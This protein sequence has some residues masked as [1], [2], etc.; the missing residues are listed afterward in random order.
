VIDSNDSTTAA[1]ADKVT[2]VGVAELLIIHVGS[3]TEAVA[4][5]LT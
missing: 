4:A 5:T 3:Q 1:E 2:R